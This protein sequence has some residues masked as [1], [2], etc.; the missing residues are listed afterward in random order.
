MALYA[1][2]YFTLSLLLLEVEC[3]NLKVQDFLWFNY[4]CRNAFIYGPA[5][6]QQGKPVC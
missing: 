3:V 2:V 4:G 1:G 5:L 6:V